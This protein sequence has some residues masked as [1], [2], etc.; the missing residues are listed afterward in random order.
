MEEL[1]HPAV[2]GAKRRTKIACSAPAT[3]GISVKPVQ[4][5]EDMDEAS[6][7]DVEQPA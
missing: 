4:E 1:W 7:A 3:R 5:I 6:L 2:G